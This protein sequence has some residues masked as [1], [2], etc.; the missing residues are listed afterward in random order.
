[1]QPAPAPA[2]APQPA[3]HHH[4][5]PPVHAMKSAVKVPSHGSKNVNGLAERN[6]PVA[7]S[8]LDIPSASARLH[9]ENHD[10]KPVS[11]LFKL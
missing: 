10:E 1:M 4:S 5:P 3:P 6:V 2:P 9:R 8:A 11:R 7:R